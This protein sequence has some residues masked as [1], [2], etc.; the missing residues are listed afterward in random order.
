MWQRDQINSSESEEGVG[1][2]NT[3]KDSIIM[4]QVVH[5]SLCDDCT[6]IAGR[7]D[8]CFDLKRSGKD[9]I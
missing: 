7:L 4:D 6:D 8:S 5:A 1:K 2:K 9:S 3:R